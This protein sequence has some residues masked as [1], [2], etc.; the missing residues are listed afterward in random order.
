MLIGYQSFDD[1]RL[2]SW[3]LLIKVLVMGDQSFADGVKVL[4]DYQS[5]SDR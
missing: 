5:V 4:I 3:G 2:N 1:R